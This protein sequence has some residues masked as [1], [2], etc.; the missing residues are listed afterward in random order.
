M[1]GDYKGLVNNNPEKTIAVKYG[2]TVIVRRNEISDWMYL[3]NNVLVGGY[4]IRVIRNKMSKEER[5]RMD[6]EAGFI[7]K[8]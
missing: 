8:D 2:D 7:I 6:K 5:I 3:D 4:T 1:N